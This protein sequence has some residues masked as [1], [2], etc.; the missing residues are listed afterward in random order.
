LPGNSKDGPLCNGSVTATSPG[1]SSSDTS[2]T[3][4]ADAEDASFRDFLLFDLRLK[5]TF[6]QNAGQKNYSLRSQVTAHILAILF[7][8][9]CINV[10]KFS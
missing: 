9:P 5:N 8:S 4:D 6:T 10:V 7:C 3:W 1:V 2:G